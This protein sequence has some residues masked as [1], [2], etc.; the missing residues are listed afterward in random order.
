MDDVTPPPRNLPQAFRVLVV[1]DS[2]RLRERVTNALTDDGFLVTV[3]ANGA[4]AYS[5]CLEQAPDLIV[6]SLEL[7]V[8][9]GWTLVNM[10]LGR[11]SLAE[12]PI[13]ILSEDA[14]DMTRLRAY[15]LGVRDFVH[16]PFTDEELCIR[17]RR[18]AMQD[19]PVGQAVVLRG[20]TAQIGVPTL[21]SLL[22]F[23][24]K[25]GI[26]VLLRGEQAVRLFVANG[27]I[28]K[29]EGPIDDGD[30]RER[31]MLVLDWIDGNFEFV[32]CEVVGADEIGMP[33]TSLLLEHARFSDEST[34]ED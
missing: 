14:G 28:V 7:P 32:A 19:R 17:V 27:R 1:D 25:S 5:E 18:I 24:R 22:E 13:M 26:L 6:A 34:R 23:E 3:V 30:A 10:L 33:T 2:P 15:R 9:D 20:D 11:P 21:L 29:V 31:V 8:M 16:K 4:E 12:I